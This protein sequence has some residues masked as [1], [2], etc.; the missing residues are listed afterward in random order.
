MTVQIPWGEVTEE[1]VVEMTEEERENY[2]RIVAEHIDF[3]F[4]I[5]ST[6]TKKLINV[7]IWQV[8]FSANSALEMNRT[9]LTRV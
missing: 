2:Q 6:I 1:M 3:W 7:N 4:P 9:L 8:Y 5:S